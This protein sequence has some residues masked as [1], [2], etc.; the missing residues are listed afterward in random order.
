MY[1]LKMLKRYSALEI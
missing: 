1:E